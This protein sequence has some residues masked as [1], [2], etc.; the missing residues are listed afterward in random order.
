MVYCWL[1]FL[2]QNFFRCAACFFPSA[3]AAFNSVQGGKRADIAK[4]WL[5]HLSSKGATQTAATVN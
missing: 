1:S 2:S 4:F 5:A 3:E